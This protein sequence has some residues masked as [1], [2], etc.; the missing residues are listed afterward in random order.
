MKQIRQQFILFYPSIDINSPISQ[1]R[2][3]K[4][5]TLTAT[6]L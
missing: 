5:Y 1:L 2:T 4:N 6:G 3:H